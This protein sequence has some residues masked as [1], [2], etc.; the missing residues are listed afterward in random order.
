MIGFTEYLNLAE[1]EYMTL[2]R[3]G[4]WSASKND[5]ASGFF[6]E[7][8]EESSYSTERETDWRNKWLY[9]GY[10]RGGRSHSCGIGGCNNGGRR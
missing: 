4:K 6:V 2:Y 1:V 10:G 8:D 7:H 5:L 3:A 9:T